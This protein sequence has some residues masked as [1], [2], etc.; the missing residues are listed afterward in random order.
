MKVLITNVYS[1]KNKGDAAIVVALVSE[2]RRVFPEADILIQT[3]DIKNDSDRYGAPIS[4]T[5]LWLLLSAHRSK[6]LAWRLLKLAGGLFGLT[7]YLLWPRRLSRHRPGWLLD[8]GLRNFVA[9]QAEADIVIACGGGYLR[10]ASAGLGDLIL[11]AVTGLNFLAGHYLGRPVYLYS[12][13]IGPVHGRL[14]RRILRFCLQRVDLIESREDITGRFLAGLKLTTPVLA[15]ADPVFLL[16][17]RGT[18]PPMALAPAKLQVGLTVRKW[19]DQ[20]RDLAQYITAVAKTIDYLSATY[21]AHV[22]YLP[23]VIAA[24]FGDDDRLIAERVQREV[25]HKAAFTLLT[26]DLHPLE[27][28]GFCGQMDIFIGTR[29]HSNIFALIN[30]VPVVAIEYEHK[31]RGIMRGLGLEDFVVAIAKAT[32]ELLKNRVD[33]LLTDRERYSRQITTNLVGEVA[34]SRHAMEAIRED[35]R[36]HAK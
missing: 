9:E 3:T 35:Y 33:Q 22:Y 14:Q 21:G 23:Q 32:P 8:A 16:Q 11:L 4:A 36:R 29:M 19:F 20:D 1:Y 12:Q 7:C 34:K 10:T 31:T 17:G 13:S 26:A 6:P 5:L 2:V 28:I 15:T 18:K 30:A 24:N 27:L 25:T